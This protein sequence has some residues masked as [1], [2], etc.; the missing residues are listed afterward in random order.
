MSAEDQLK[1]MF[2]R[3]ADAAGGKEGSPGTTGLTTEQLAARCTCGHPVAQHRV[4]GCKPRVTTNLIKVCGCTRS[5]ADAWAS[6][7]RRA[8]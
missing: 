3:A 7:K 1:E 4:T 2:Q 5:R 8:P 6:K